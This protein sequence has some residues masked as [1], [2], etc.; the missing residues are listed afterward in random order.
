MAVPE[1]PALQKWPLIAAQHQGMGRIEA[2]MS[3]C[4]AC[5]AV[6]ADLDTEIRG[7]AAVVP[8]P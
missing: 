5:I 4:R 2:Q 8:A 6:R 7:T 1:Q 3:A